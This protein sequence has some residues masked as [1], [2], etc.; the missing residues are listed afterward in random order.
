MDFKK[1]RVHGFKSFVDPVEL[2]IEPGITG[3]VGPNGCGK[4]NVIESLRWVMGEAS[5]K[6]MRGGEMD[7][8]IFGGSSGR[9]QRNSAEVTVTLD[10]KERKAPAAFND[11]DELEISRRIDR[12][13]GSTYRINGKEVR[14]RDVQL[15]FADLAT[16]A[17]STAIVSQGRVG[18]L[19]GAKPTDRRTL[20]EEAA[21]IRGLHSRRHEAELRLRAAESNLERLEDVIGALESQFSGLQRQARQANRYRK[22][23]E[24]LRAQEAILLHLRWSAADAAVGE[25]KGHLAEA[26]AAVAAKTQAAAETTSLQTRA[27]EI[28]PK[29][30]EAE[31]EAAARLQAQ[32]IAERQ[33][34]DEAERVGEQLEGLRRQLDQIA[35]D[36]AREEVLSHDATEAL[37]ALSEEQ[38]TLSAAQADEAGERDRLRAERDDADRTVAEKEETMEA[39]NQ[40]VAAVEAQRDGLE[41]Q[42]GEARG[43][44]EALSAQAT[45]TEEE[46]TSLRERI[47]SLGDPKGAQTAVEEAETALAAA[48]SALEAMESDRA[49][50]EQSVDSARARLSTLEADQRKALDAARDQARL[51]LSTAEQQGR[52]AILQAERTGRDS[53]TAIEREGREKSEAARRTMDAIQTEIRAIKTLLAD[54]DD[55]GDPVLER[56]EV[57]PGLEAALGSALGDDLEAG[58]SPQDARHWFDLGPM[59]EAPALPDGALPLAEMV[60]APAALARRLSQI[61]VVEDA[62]AAERLQALLKAGQ[63]I[64]SKDGGL[65]RWD[66]LLVKP[67]TV[68]AAARR[69]EQRNK[70]ADLENR[71]GPAEAAFNEAQSDAV[72]EL[73]RAKSSAEEQLAKSKE[74][75]E[76]QIADATRAGTDAINTA[77]QQMQS[78]IAEAKQAADEAIV[79]GQSL[80]ARTIEARKNQQDAFQTAGA[81]RQA[82]SDLERVLLESQN[83]H[84]VLA[85]DAQ[86]LAQ[87]IQEA[88]E[89]ID[90]SNQAMGVLE[91]IEALR[92]R[93]TQTRTVLAELRARQVE[94]RSAYDRIEREAATRAARLSS[95]ERERM[96]W[97]QRA[98]GAT[99]RL[100]EL[101]ER[102]LETG[103]EMTA[104][105]E[106][107][108]LLAEKRADM[109]TRI[110]ELEE[111]RKAAA[112]KLAEA[113]GAQRDTDT[114]LKQAEAALALAREERVRREA[115]VEQALQ[116]VSQIAERIAEKLECEPAEALA[117]SGLAEDAALPEADDVERRI[118][119]LSR[120]RDNIGP[121]NLRAEQEADELEEQ[122]ASMQ[123]E[124][125]DLI[126][127]ISRLRQG[128]NA[129]N[130]EGR[131]RLLKAFEEVD[132]HF[133]DLFKTLFG[134]GEAHLKLTESDDPLLAGLE[135]M[136]MPPGK[137]MQVLSLLSGGEQALTALALLFGVFLTNPAPICVLDEVDAPLDDSN[138]DRFCEMLDQISSVGSTRFLVVT[139]H[140]MTMA[141]MDRLFGV[142]MA[143]RGVSQLVSVDL[144][145]AERFREAS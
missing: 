75:A 113:E 54:E 97:T 67:G 30:R 1:L 129:L 19:I 52:D 50:A 130:R 98:E 22:I 58:L 46:Q 6:R 28:L 33:I 41:R 109:Q 110:A 111:A 83:R 47:G 9:P 106:R 3:V 26:E 10:N 93:Q 25:A 107:P 24:Q 136:A 35:T 124:R 45:R 105:E 121:V 27:H 119:R 62:E 34:A 55:G 37:T 59:Q 42:I 120:E 86:R 31:A 40:H 118:E 63:R 92:E 68:T 11:T 15:L 144:R 127:A 71:V 142:T 77:E 116:T 69:L 20:L 125:D 84:A 117:Q 90:A 122:I 16:G 101:D 82:L 38:A 21:G 29:L 131:E 2:A 126:A 94:K 89:R 56:M 134:G 14:A 23:S 36:A 99:K 141:R 103:R 65:W 108:A 18:A 112:D 139:H 135:I 145:Q 74:K 66:G 140:R 81:A 53:V 85:Q 61:G 5:A 95:I 104:L 49:L 12:G 44:I 143:E 79:A 60:R 78:A 7:D 133:Q 88:K 39:L 64:V 115:A 137:K 73:E 91:D 96:G 4:S 102:R 17:N 87:D 76:L 8:V 132:R 100:K 72:R 128:I 80:G 57:A 13:Q 138:V 43:R 51:A 114:A 123:S 32:V 70:L 48:T